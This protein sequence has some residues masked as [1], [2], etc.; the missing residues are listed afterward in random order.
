MS[1]Y[2]QECHFLARLSG[3]GVMACSAGLTWKFFV[4]LICVLVQSPTCCEQL[5]G[6]GFG[7]VGGA[8]ST[9][10]LHFPAS[11]GSRCRCITRERSFPED[12]MM[13][14]SHF[15]YGESISGVAADVTRVL[16]VRGGAHL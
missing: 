15:D 12:L 2:C 16:N 7:L 5:I 3:D 10:V 4:S 8:Q 6:P 1:I 14:V 13:S 9:P 11:E